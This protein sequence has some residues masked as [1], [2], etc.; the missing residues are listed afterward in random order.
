MALALRF[1]H[2]LGMAVFVGGGLAAWIV[3]RTSHDQRGDAALALDRLHRTLARITNWASVVLVVS[4]L[5]AIR[6]FRW[7]GPNMPRETWLL[8]MLV[9][10][11][12]AAAIAGVAG[13]RTRKLLAMTTDEARTAARAKL[14]GLWAAFL[15]LC[16]VAA[17][18]GV[19]RFRL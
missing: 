6:A 5:G 10:G 17:A 3:G 15:V 2:L 11:I 14:S 12:A 18:S 9:A 13:G 4:G 1:L 7:D 16:V 19:F 8:V